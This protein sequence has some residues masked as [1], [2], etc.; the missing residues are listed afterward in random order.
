MT[1]YDLL[2]TEL[3]SRF[4]PNCD[5]RDLGVISGV[6]ADL[7]LLQQTQTATK[8]RSELGERYDQSEFGD[9]GLVPTHPRTFSVRL[10]LCVHSSF[11]PPV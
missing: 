7:K 4:G 6:L 1:G 11:G 2:L 3:A 10:C 8:S 5:G 9:S